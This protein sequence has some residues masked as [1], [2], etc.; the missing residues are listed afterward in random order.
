MNDSEITT[1]IKCIILERTGKIIPIEMNSN[2]IYNKN[3]DITTDEFSTNSKELTVYN[4]IEKKTQI[5]YSY[6]IYGSD[7]KHLLKENKHELLSPYDTTIFYGDLLV[8]KYK[9]EEPININEDD[10]FFL[11]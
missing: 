1:I 10:S 9:N 4:F 3:F 11:Q 6:K 2:E 8:I 5:K 7:N